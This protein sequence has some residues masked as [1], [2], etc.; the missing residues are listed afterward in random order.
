M[1]YYIVALFDDDSYKCLHPIQRNYSKKFKANRNSPI[2]HIILEVVENPNIDKLDA[3]IQKI[4]QPYKKFKVEIVPSV[5][6]C[7]ANK[8]VAL[9]IQDKGYIK[10]FTRLISDTLKLNNFSLKSTSAPI[11]I[12]LANLN[13]VNKDIKKGDNEFAI[14]TKFETLKVSR[15]ELWKISNSKRETLIKTYHLKDF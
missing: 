14:D 10:R 12:S 1:K 11:N 15:I 2:P 7:E 5:F 13:Y 6:V 3:I 8:T 4:T 9:S